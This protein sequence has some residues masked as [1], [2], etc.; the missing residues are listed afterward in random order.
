MAKMIEELRAQGHSV[1]DMTENIQ[2]FAFVMDRTLPG[3]PSLRGPSL[4]W[5]E[6]VDARTGSVAKI[7]HCVSN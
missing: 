7:I 3:L 4:Q 5:D 6:H 2:R 1:E